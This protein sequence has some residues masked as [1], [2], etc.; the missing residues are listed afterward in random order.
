MG[1]IIRAVLIVAGI[2]ASWFIAKDAVNFPI[3]QMVV[4]L[5]LIVFVVAVLALWRRR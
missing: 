4:A 1:W 2:V 5:L 3:F